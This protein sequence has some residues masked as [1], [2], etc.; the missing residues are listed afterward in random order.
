MIFLEKGFYDK[1]PLIY[2]DDP[3]LSTDDHIITEDTSLPATYALRD[4]LYPRVEEVLSTNVGNSKYR[5]IVARFIDKNNEKLHTAGPM[6]MIPFT[7]RDKGEFYNLFHVTE[8]EI[9]DVTTQVRKNI[10]VDS[11]FRYI[12][13][14]PCLFLL[15]CCIRYYTLK[16]DNMGLKI[17]VA[18]YALAVYPSVFDKYYKYG[19][20]NP[21]VMD[22]TMDNLTKKFIFKQQ[23]NLFNTLTY[24]AQHSY[25]TL[26]LSIED[27]SDKEAIRWIQRIRNDQNS[28]MKKVR[29]Q[30]EKNRL[31]GN[32][33]TSS[34]EMNKEGEL[35]DTY[36][37]N[38]SEVELVTRAVALPLITNGINMQHAQAAGN[39]GH[40]SVVDMRFYISKILTS[41][42][43]ESIEKFIQSIVF[44]WI[45]DE[46]H[47]RSQI[48]TSEFFV[49]GGKLFQRTNSNDPNVSTIKQTL[50]NWTDM[51]GITQ[52]FTREATRINYK[53]AIFF[54][55]IISIQY[56]NH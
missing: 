32:Q 13:N 55:F 43:A 19:V 11:E 14:N 18:M 47:T 27:G 45:Y 25:A 8:K 48:N 1:D 40:V 26:R 24:S 54:Y 34:L 33:I 15:Y 52:K 36:T 41:E 53:K 38:T 10:G 21:G 30:Y 5:D 12:K 56:Y 2:A 37:N 50:T 31:K 46:K 4:Q 17:S 16:K 42:N 35:I 29:D 3:S 22:Y 51:V 44:I 39:I 7:D 9:N 6:Y 49:W 20:S 28:M 23:G